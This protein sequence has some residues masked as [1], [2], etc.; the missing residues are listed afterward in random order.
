MFTL[1]KNIINAQ[2]VKIRSDKAVRKTL[3]DAKKRI[4][5]GE[6]A[7]SKGL[8][9]YLNEIDAR[10]EPIKVD[11]M[12]TTSTKGYA[13]SR[14]AKLAKTQRLIDFTD[15]DYMKLTALNMKLKAKAE[16]AGLSSSYEQGTAKAPD[17]QPLKEELNRL[18][19]GEEEMKKITT[20]INATK[21]GVNSTQ[22]PRAK[23]VRKV[24]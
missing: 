9:L 7:D 14:A 2:V 22:S 15:N 3:R 16:A 8:S 18:I 5:R 19:A 20:T 17:M 10:F 21:L 23:K 12:N 24:I 4:R 11:I 6:L 1:R 13:A